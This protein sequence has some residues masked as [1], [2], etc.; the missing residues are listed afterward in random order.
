MKETITARLYALEHQGQQHDLTA[1]TAAD[2][3][4]QVQALTGSRQAA[5]LA[6]LTWG[7]DQA[8]VTAAG[9]RLLAVGRVVRQVW[10]AT[11]QQRR[12]VP[13]GQTHQAQAV[14]DQAEQPVP[15]LLD[16]ANVD[17]D[18]TGRADTE[19]QR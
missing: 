15:P 10:R 4:A 2:L 11:P 1:S 8:D 12:S 9:V 13:Q 14:P 6:R 17:A 16:S 18:A 3:V 7:D 19:P 5:Q